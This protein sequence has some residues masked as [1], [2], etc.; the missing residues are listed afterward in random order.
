MKLIDSVLLAS[1]PKSID[2]AKNTLSAVARDMGFDQFSYVGGRAFK[3]TTGGKAIWHRPP[4]VLI[5]FPDEWVGL[6]HSKDLSTI[7]PIVK[8]TLDLR[9]PYSW[10]TENWRG[11]LGKNQTGFFREAH[12][13]RVCR[14][15]SI[16]IY[17]P[18]GEFSLFTFISHTRSEEY[19]R[20]IADRK[21]DVHLLALYYH[22]IIQGL[23]PHPSGEVALT[24][25]EEEV[26]YWTA[27]GKTS[28]EIGTILSLSQKTVQF[29]LYKSMKKLDVY[30]KPQAV[31]RAILLGLIKP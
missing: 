21:H 10:D 23:D 5:T 14:G 3:P 26:L 1:R 25:R 18:L 27:A 22:Q 4:K 6:Y 16:P 11:E 2:E 28:D 15:I 8:A 9:L 29:H 17:G 7:D 12:D 31:A 30:S 13:F 20:L 19:R 24:E